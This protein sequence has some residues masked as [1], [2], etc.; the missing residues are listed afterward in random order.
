MLWFWVGFGLLTLLLLVLGAFFTMRLG[1]ISANARVQVE[2]ARPRAVATRELEI[3]SLGYAL[4]V[5]SVLDGFAEARK[6]AD[7][8]VANVA[9]NL[10]EYERLAKSA[11]EHQLSAKFGTRWSQLHELGE[12]M[13]AAGH[14][15]PEEMASLLHLRLQLEQ[16]LD[17]EMQPDA[18]ASQD[19]R[20]DATLSNLKSTRDV[21]SLLLIACLGIALATSLSV[22]NKLRRTQQELIRRERMATLGQLAGSVA[23]HIRSPLCVI[24]NSIYFLEQSHPIADQSVREVLAEM[25]RSVRK[26]DLII[27]QMLDYVREP[28]VHCKVFPIGNAISHALQLVDIPD[29][30]HIRPLPN[31]SLDTAVRAQPD[32][33]TSILVN[34][35]ENAIQSM[36]AGGDLDVSVTEEGSEKLCVQVRDTGCGIP[37]ENLTSVFN[38][39]FSTRIKGIGLGLAIAQRY[40]DSNRGALSVD[41]QVGRGTTFR[42]TLQRAGTGCETGAA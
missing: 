39:L 25:K 23:H 17:G 26:S 42:L 11:L 30:V 12:R 14:A 9:Y 20:T 4:N 27:T 31:E 18:F 40:A 16:L 19:T 34:L 3:H 22:A 38:P 24:Q 8:D 10:A 6:M 13:L 36:P 29:S 2:I 35:I 1:E 33:V 32:Q 15:S 5:R 41:S 7:E 37:E 28:S 21:T